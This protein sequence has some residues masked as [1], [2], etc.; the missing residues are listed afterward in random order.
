MQSVE[1]NA[2]WLVRSRDW[3]LQ[4][5]LWR[6]R[7][8]ASFLRG[9]DAIALVS[10]YLSNV[11]LVG[12]LLTKND[13]IVVDELSHNSIIVATGVA[14][15]RVVR[16]AHNDLD[17]LESILRG[18]RSD[19]NRALI[20]VEGLYSMDGDIADLPRL[21]EIRNRYVRLVRILPPALSDGV[22]A[23]LRVRA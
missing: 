8:L 23:R 17:H 7:E 15:A 18:Q 5:P 10:G 1:S 4:P 11:S 21:I 6:R 16:F 12:H 14:R 2:G 13:L 9:D 22:L 3:W 19:V 20:I